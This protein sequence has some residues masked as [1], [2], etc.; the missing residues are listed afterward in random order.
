MMDLK[1][2]NARGT[3]DAVPFLVFAVLVTGAIG[4]LVLVAPPTTSNATANT[5]P[6]SNT[7]RYETPP[8]EWHSPPKTVIEQGSGVET[9]E[10][11]VF[12]GDEGNFYVK[13]GDNG[14]IVA[15]RPDIGLAVTEACQ[16]APS[17]EKV[18]VFIPG[19]GYFQNNAIVVEN[20]DGIDLFGPGDVSTTLH[21]TDNLA[22]ENFLLVK[23]GSAFYMHDIKFMSANPD[24][25]TPDPLP[26]MTIDTKT[27]LKFF[28]I[29]LRDLHIDDY[30]DS[31]W[32]RVNDSI[33]I[34]VEW[35]VNVPKDGFQF[36]SNKWVGGGGL[37]LGYYDGTTWHAAGKRYTIANNEYRASL[38]SRGLENSTISGNIFYIGSGATNYELDIYHVADNDPSGV[39]VTNNLF[40][41][42][43]SPAIEVSSGAGTRD[44]VGV[45]ITG[46][47]FPDLKPAVH[48]I[49]QAGSD[50]H[51]QAS[52]FGNTN[53]TIDYDVDNSYDNVKLISGNS[54]AARAEN[55][56]FLENAR[57]TLEQMRAVTMP[58]SDWA[59][60]HHFAWDV[61][62]SNWDLVFKW[63]T[64]P[65]EN[66]VVDYICGQRLLQ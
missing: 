49:Y 1:M 36:V 17:D 18:D 20:C 43:A 58:A 26:V 3:S 19:G 40:S 65:G 62:E 7:S 14:E 57:P 37:D 53:N 60:S 55:V 54:P 25:S 23:E 15:E 34:N 51:A 45:T 31:Q 29:E 63:E 50:L 12:E 6:E 56:S 4:G 11:I 33:F 8:S 44:E 9:A 21:P 59:V 13:S 28:E 47:K 46:N 38:Y 24:G 5:A 52:I 48:A 16:I 32:Q 10:F 41:G 35:D 27:E 66:I 64:D 22:G 42:T 2:K 61:S 30:N 39:S